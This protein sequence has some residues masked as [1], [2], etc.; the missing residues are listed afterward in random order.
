[1][2]KEKIIKRLNMDCPIC[3][4]YHTVLLVTKKGYLRHYRNSRLIRATFLKCENVADNKEEG[5][6][7]AINGQ[8][9]MAETIDLVNCI[10]PLIFCTYLEKENW[11]LCL[12]N[13]KD[14]N[15]YQKDYQQITIPLNKDASDYIQSMFKALVLVANCEDRSE[16]QLTLDLLPD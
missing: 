5:L 1:M 12:K 8:Y 4:H 3:G 2:E 13:W 14:I 9:L 10:D 6:D 15:I 16:M 7:F 11:K